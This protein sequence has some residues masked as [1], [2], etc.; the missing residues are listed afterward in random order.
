M[1]APEF[2]NGEP[3]PYPHIAGGDTSRYLIL[4][5][6][7][8]FCSG[9]D[10]L[11]GYCIH[12]GL[13]ICFAINIP[14]G[15]SCSRI[16]CSWIHAQGRR[17]EPTASYDRCR[18]SVVTVGTYGTHEARIIVITIILVQKSGSQDG[19]SPS[20]LTGVLLDADPFHVVP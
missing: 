7:V 19:A 6:L 4:Q 11:Y 14:I 16:G 1:V 12:L 2:R 18:C 15:S 5:S 17:P 9:Y 10:G 20:S 8:T 3:Q 13:D